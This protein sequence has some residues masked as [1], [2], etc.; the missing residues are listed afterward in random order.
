MKRQDL[1][2]KPTERG[3]RPWLGPIVFVMFCLLI[4]SGIVVWCLLDDLRLITDVDFFFDTKSLQGGIVQRVL[5]AA[6]G[7][8]AAYV[9]G[10]DSL[11]RE[12]WTN[13]MSV[14]CGGLTV[15][16]PV[17]YLLD[18][19]FFRFISVVLFLGVMAVFVTRGKRF[20]GNLEYFR[21]W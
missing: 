6:G 8:I 1:V 5:G 16:L 9:L 11:S 20:D 13:V 4:G 10:R 2:G 14:V 18:R 12:R 3:K 17:F 15:H 21:R 19:S 7:L